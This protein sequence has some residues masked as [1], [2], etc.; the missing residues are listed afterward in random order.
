MHRVQVAGWRR[1]RLR[2]LEGQKNL[3][4]FIASC[5][6][7]NFQM[8]TKRKQIYALSEEN[9]FVYMKQVAIPQLNWKFATKFSKNRSRKS[10]QYALI[11]RSTMFVER[12]TNGALPARIKLW[13]SKVRKSY[14]VVRV[15]FAKKFLK[16]REV[17]VHYSC[18]WMHLCRRKCTYGGQ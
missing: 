17:C 12:I 14:H 4:Y 1:V 6:T 15:E 11:V 10:Q 7:C 5:N 2:K 13:K 3:V 8:L 16:L 9:W 18:K